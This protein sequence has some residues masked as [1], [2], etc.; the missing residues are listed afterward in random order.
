MLDRNDHRQIA[1]DQKLLHFQDEAP[2]MVFWHPRGLELF[3]C[4]ERAARD[5]LS[6]HGYREVRTPELMRQAIWELSGH[7]Q[8]FDEGMFRLQEDDA[9]GIALKP[10]NCPGH[11]Q[12]YRQEIRSYRDLPLRLAEFGVVH[13]KEPSGALQGLFRLREFT[14]DDGHVFCRP[15]QLLAELSRFCRSLQAFYRR[16]GFDDLIVALSTRPPARIGDDA[17]WDRAEAALAS[18]A[19][20]LGLPVLEQPGEGAFYG[21]KLEFQ[22]RDR[23]RRVW[24]C[25]TIQVDF[26]MP[27]RF[28]LVY[29]DSDGERRRPVM[30]HRALYGSVERFIG[31]LLE[32]H[33]GRLPAWLA[34]EQAHVL[35]V[36][37]SE[38]EYAEELARA[39]R[40]NQVRVVLTDASERLAS[41]VAEARRAGAA[42]VLVVGSSERASREVSVSSWGDGSPGRAAER[43]AFDA[44]VARVSRAARPPAGS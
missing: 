16:F 32:H 20:E 38:A 35:P 13:R 24:Q 1:K 36:T 3:R 19:S 23:L 29:A 42:F 8:H 4:L 21:P 14:Q 44:A 30:L 7:W 37:A 39:L 27:E 12:I 31:V 2:G 25:G 15:D 11:V 41:R 40:Q 26:A 43:A 33:Q 28:E 9:S 22:L 17:S 6:L 18:A 10:V 5:E 34:P